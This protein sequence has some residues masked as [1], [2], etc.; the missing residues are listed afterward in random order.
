MCS[1]INPDCVSL[2]SDKTAVFQLGEW[3]PST[4]VISN[5]LKPQD[6]LVD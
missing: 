6:S 2:V 1:Q 5:R 4:T 3:G